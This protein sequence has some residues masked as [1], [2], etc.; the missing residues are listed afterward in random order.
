MDVV[1]EI[2]ESFNMV[3]HDMPITALCTY[4]YHPSERSRPLTKYERKSLYVSHSERS[5]D[6]KRIMYCIVCYVYEYDDRL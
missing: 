1:D 6:L 2:S 4:E 5:N 3:Q